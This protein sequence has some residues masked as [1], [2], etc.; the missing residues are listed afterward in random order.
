MNVL[1][2]IPW[3]FANEGEAGNVVCASIC[4]GVTDGLSLRLIGSAIFISPAA[5][6]VESKDEV[7]EDGSKSVI[8]SKGAKFTLVWKES[9]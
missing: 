2:G 1:R 7:I 3:G 9:I 4:P 8:I 6:S 5:K